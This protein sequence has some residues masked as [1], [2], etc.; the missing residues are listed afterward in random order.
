[1]SS[2]CVAKKYEEDEY[3]RGFCTSVY[4]SVMVAAFAAVMQV[5][6]NLIFA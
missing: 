6:K 1:M 4:F 5:I 3:M 2:R